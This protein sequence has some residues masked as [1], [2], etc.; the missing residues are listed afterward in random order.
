MLFS[1]A[2]SVFRIVMALAFTSCIRCSHSMRQVL[3]TW[4]GSASNYEFFI[5]YHLSQQVRYSSHTKGTSSLKLPP[6]CCQQCDVTATWDWPFGS[7]QAATWVQ[8]IAWSCA[9]Q[10][11]NHNACP[12]EELGLNCVGITPPYMHTL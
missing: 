12:W 3:A 10:V 5:L 8:H 6:L 1:E 2:A 9:A 11:A 7:L 4:A